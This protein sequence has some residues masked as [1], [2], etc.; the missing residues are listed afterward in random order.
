M[1]E[2]VAHLDEYLL[3]IVNQSSIAA[4]QSAPI[5]IALCGSHH[6]HA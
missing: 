5:R 1:P 2:E 4:Q 3:A 6:V